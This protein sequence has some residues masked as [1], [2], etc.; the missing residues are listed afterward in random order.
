MAHLLLIV[1][2]HDPSSSEV[3]EPMFLMPRDDLEQLSQHIDHDVPQPAHNNQSDSS[4]VERPMRASHGATGWACEGPSDGADLVR[5]WSAR[6][7]VHRE[8]VGAV[9]RTYR[10]LCARGLRIRSRGE[11][12]ID[13]HMHMLP[14]AATS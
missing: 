2:E 12:G 1:R 7:A 3:K 10:Y 4:S 13:T 5:R 9:Q 14:R 6:G 8:I 11:A